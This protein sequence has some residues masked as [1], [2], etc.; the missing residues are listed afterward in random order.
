[1]FHRRRS[2]KGFTLVEL[3]VVIGIIALLAGILLPVLARATA[4]AKSARCK[5]RLGQLYKGLRMY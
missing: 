3:L 2:A 5:S 1:M 4:Q